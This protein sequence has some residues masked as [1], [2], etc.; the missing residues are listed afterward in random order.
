MSN[1]TLSVIGRHEPFLSL[2]KYL[3]VL[4]INSIHATVM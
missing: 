2:S 4:F 3:F 1:N